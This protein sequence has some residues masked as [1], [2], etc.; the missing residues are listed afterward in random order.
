MAA[1]TGLHRFKAPHL[2]KW[3][4]QKWNMLRWTIKYMN[5]NVIYVWYM[6]NM[7][8]IFQPITH[9]GNY[10]AGWSCLHPI[11]WFQ[12]LKDHLAETVET[13]FLRCVS[14]HLDPCLLLAKGVPFSWRCLYWSQ[15]DSLW[16]S[17]VFLIRVRLGTQL[18]LLCLQVFSSNIV[19]HVWLD[20]II[21]IYIYICVCVY[22]YIYTCI[23]HV[24]IPY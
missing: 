20:M 21:C 2:T 8:P 23:N 5:K 10:V 17:F 7:I 6:N 13:W 4:V 11:W 9:V 18:Q 14:C 1:G 16:V 19:L 24:Y 15:T 12:H 3:D 22:I